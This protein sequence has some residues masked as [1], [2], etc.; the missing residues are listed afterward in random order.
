MT[1]YEALAAVTPFARG[2][3]LSVLDALRGNGKRGGD[4]ARAFHKLNSA[5]AAAYSLGYDLG[6]AAERSGADY[7][8][9]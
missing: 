8:V 9:R 5:I 4:P 3:W 1:D 2:V 6:R 7:G